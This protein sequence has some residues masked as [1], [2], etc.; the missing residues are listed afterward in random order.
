MDLHSSGNMT[1]IKTKKRNN[2]NA[3]SGAFSLFLFLVYRML[4]CNWIEFHEF[5]LLVCMLSLILTSIVGMTFADAI[6][7]ACRY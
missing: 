5:K 3:P 1:L 6:F 7:V 2:E 4:L